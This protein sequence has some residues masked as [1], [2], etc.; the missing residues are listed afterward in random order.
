[1][2][3]PEIEVV[4]TK[5]QMEHLVENIKIATKRNER[6]L[7][8]TLT[9]RMSEDL[10]DYLKGLGIRC[11]YMHS[12][13]DTI[14]RVKILRGLRLKQFDVL[15]G[16]NLLRE[17][18]D[19]PEVSVVAVLDADK[20]GFLRSR[21]SLIQVAGRAARNINGKVF[22][23]GDKV[24]DSMQNLIDE[25]S[26][27]RKIQIDFNKKNNIQPKTIL[28]NIEQIKES[29]VV[30]KDDDMDDIISSDEKLEFLDMDSFES[31]EIVKDIEQK[32]L[33]YAKELQFE[34]AALL[35]DQLEKIK[36]KDNGK[37]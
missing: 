2:L 19:L 6:V 1:M 26:R 28:K 3:D 7:V 16:I 15:V 31:K 23:Y 37:K 29:T 17:G 21:S 20:E 18:L 27:R 4:K 34:K 14:E 35:R 11:E 36:S 13:V 10:T 32:M 12:E 24:T 22:L 30:A 25:T 5:G 33:N 9:K 8:T